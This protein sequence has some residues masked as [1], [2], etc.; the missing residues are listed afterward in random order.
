[1]TDDAERARRARLRTVLRENLMRRKAQAWSRRH[2][3]PVSAAGPAAPHEA[4]CPPDTPAP[5]DVDRPS[6]Q[7]GEIEDGP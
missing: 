3:D 6:L 7:D 1:M 5:Q 2:Q 4:E